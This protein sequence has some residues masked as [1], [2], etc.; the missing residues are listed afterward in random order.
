M[1]TTFLVMTSIVHLC[2]LSLDRYISLFYALVYRTIV[3]TT[4]VKIGV[5][6]A[7]IFAS[8]ASFIQLVWL[9]PILSNSPTTDEYYTTLDRIEACYSI[10]TF[11]MFMFA[12]S[13]FLAFLYAQI[14]CQIRFLLKRAP[15]EVIS[16]YTASDGRGAKQRHA[17]YMFASM[18][19]LFLILTL[20]YFTLRLYNDIVRAWHPHKSIVVDHGTYELIYTMKYFT[21]LLNP[22]LYMNREYKMFAYS[23]LSNF[24]IQIR[25]IGQQSLERIRGCVFRKK[26]KIEAVYHKATTGEGYASPELLRIEQYNNGY[27][28][29]SNLPSLQA[30]D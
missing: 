4:R 5:A 2:G 18:F 25:N 14:F 17:L 13:I 23:K 30:Y 26:F 22:L 11:A 9:E 19:L 21:S 24:L 3:T 1:F 10:A 15:P 20:P 8:V 7:W 27:Q 28:D 6:C 12:P 16:I 29:N